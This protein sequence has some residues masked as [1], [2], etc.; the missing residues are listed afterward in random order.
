MRKSY[1]ATLAVCVGSVRTFSRPSVRIDGMGYY[2][3][4]ASVV[5]DH[6][7]DLRNEFLYTSPWMRK[8]YF[9]ALDGRARDPYPVGAA[10]LWAP[11]FYLSYLLDPERSSHSSYVRASPGFNPRYVRTIA[12]ATGL[13]VLL[14]GMLLYLGMRRRSGDAAALAG[15][16]GAALGTP[17]VFY[18]LAEPSYAHAASFLCGSAL[19][20]AVLVD[21]ERRLPL[22]ALGALWGSASWCAG[23]MPSSACSWHRD[24]CGKS[25]GRA[26]N[27]SC[28]APR[29][30]SGS[31]SPRHSSSCLRC[32]SGSEFMAAPSS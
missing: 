28:R 18:A 1:L 20:V 25:P 14:A 30:R 6:D 7:L 13:E 26:G 12:L 27:R 5:F 15:T 11:V 23:R 21:R 10:F 22:A 3:P 32:S 29:T 24:C 17:V 9:P 2:A 4:L 16:M 31:S 19:L 8:R